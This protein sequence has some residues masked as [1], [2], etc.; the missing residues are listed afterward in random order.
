MLPDFNIELPIP[1]H[2]SVLTEHIADTADPA[3][4]CRSCVGRV[5]RS[6]EGMYMALVKHAEPATYDFPRV[7]VVWCI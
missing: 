3:G 7:S 4:L 2:E 1:V 6:N 5:G